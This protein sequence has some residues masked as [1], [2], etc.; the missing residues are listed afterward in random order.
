MEVNGDS[1]PRTKEFADILIRKG[2]IDK[3]LSYISIYDAHNRLVFSNT[4]NK[5][6]ASP[7]QP[8]LVMK[9]EIKYLGNSVDKSNLFKYMGYIEFGIN[10]MLDNQQHASGTSAVILMNRK[11]GSENPQMISSP[12]DHPYTEYIRNHITDMI[13]DPIDHKYIT[14]K[15]KNAVLHD[16]YC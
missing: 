2:V 15:V 1:L 4:K 13:S 5:P 3:S 6:S 8:L 11:T 12:M 10:S 9:K 16:P 14:V 7:T